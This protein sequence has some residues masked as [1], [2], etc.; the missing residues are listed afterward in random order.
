MSKT[1]RVELSGAEV[2][3]IS[4]RDGRRET[5]VAFNAARGGEPQITRTRRPAGIPPERRSRRARGVG[6]TPAERRVGRSAA[7]PALTAS[8]EMS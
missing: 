5:N 4:L 8:P 6:T 3:S 2:K 1:P 7:L